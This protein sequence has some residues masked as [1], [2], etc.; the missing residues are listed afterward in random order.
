MHDTTRNTI[1]TSSKTHEEV[2][3]SFPCG[4]ELPSLATLQARFTGDS[5]IAP[6]IA[7]AALWL[8]RMQEQYTLSKISSFSL[9]ALSLLSD[10]SHSLAHRVT[11]STI[12]HYYRAVKA[13]SHNQSVLQDAYVSWRRAFGEEIV[14]RIA[15]RKTKH[16]LRLLS[17]EKQC[18][19]GDLRL[20]HTTTGETT[21]AS[22]SET[23]AG[24]KGRRTRVC[25][26]RREQWQRIPH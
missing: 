3:F 14:C 25:A 11:L 13:A 23:R 7:E 22:E 6:R 12:E 16:L 17:N 20:L 10:T 21:S 26:G 19:T 15:A 24:E 2:P 18:E 9:E 8:E 5:D 4:E 1:P